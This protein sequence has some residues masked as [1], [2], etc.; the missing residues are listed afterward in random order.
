ME[1]L[2]EQ[3]RSLVASSLQLI[4]TRLDVLKGRAQSQVQSVSLDTKAHGTDVYVTQ[5][6]N[7]ITLV[8][9]ARSSQKRERVRNCTGPS[10]ALE[11][12]WLAP[13]VTCLELYW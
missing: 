5:P 1:C 11:R 9:L 10:P 13:N 12:V 4:R 7:Y 6:L 2:T 3:H 8:S